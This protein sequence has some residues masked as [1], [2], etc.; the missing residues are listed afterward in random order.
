MKGWR[1]SQIVNLYNLQMEV[2]F[3]L[4]NYKGQKIS[5]NTLDGIFKFL[6]DGGYDDGQGRSYDILDDE[7]YGD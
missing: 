1:D 4:T 3:V 7:I 2:M 6:E 5:S